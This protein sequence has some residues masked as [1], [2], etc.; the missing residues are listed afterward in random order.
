[1]PHIQMLDLILWPAFREYAVQIPEMQERMG[2]LMDMCNT[3]RCDWDLSEHEALQRNEETGLL[4]L[5][6]RAKVGRVRPVKIQCY[7]T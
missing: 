2:W 3:T 4:D 5:T 6:D 1:M 7:R